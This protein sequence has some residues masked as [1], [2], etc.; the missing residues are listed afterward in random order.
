MSARFRTCLVLVVAAAGLLA[1][2]EHHNRKDVASTNAADVVQPTLL[3]IGEETEQIVGLVPAGDW[4]QIDRYVGD[5]DAAWKDYTN[6]EAENEPQFVPLSPP[7]ATLESNVAEAVSRLRDA[8]TKQD[9]GATT[10]AAKDLNKAVTDLYEYYHV[11]APPDLHT[12]ETLERQMLVE[13]SSGSFNSAAN[14]LQRAGEVW[15]GIQPT[16]LDRAGFE[17]AQAIG[18][19]LKVQRIAIEARDH[20]A[21]VDSLETTL[22]LIE[23]VQRYY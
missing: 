19:Q 14:T 22:S 18:G 7:A 10:K 13:V 3:R 23:G 15:R 6:E 17:A 16:I 5:I 21:A 2:C 4:P 9:A 8:A 20:T 11:A 12:L 1:S